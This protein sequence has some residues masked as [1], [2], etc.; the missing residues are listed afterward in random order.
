MRRLGTP[1]RSFQGLEVLAGGRG[2]EE[3]RREESQELYEGSREEM[4]EGCAVGEVVMEW[5]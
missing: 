2:L 3:E 1:L 4:G 5:E